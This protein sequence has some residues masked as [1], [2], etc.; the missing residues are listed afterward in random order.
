MI[1]QDQ[2]RSESLLRSSMG[3]MGDLAEAFPTGEF[4]D[5]YRQDWVTAMIKEA[6]SS[7]EYSQRTIQTAKWAREQ[8]KRQTGTA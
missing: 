6:K 1:F 7:R 2:N 4:A 3:V 8:V 5:F